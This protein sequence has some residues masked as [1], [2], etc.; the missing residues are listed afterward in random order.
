MS[1]AEKWVEVEIVLSK[2]SQALHNK[3]D[4]LS[5]ISRI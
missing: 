3:Y 5:L 2:I 4:M 1:V